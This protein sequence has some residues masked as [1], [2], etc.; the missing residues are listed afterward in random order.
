MDF[1]DL[2]LWGKVCVCWG[3][4]GG[5][6]V[7]WCCSPDGAQR[8]GQTIAST[9]RK[10]PDF[11]HCKVFDQIEASVVWLLIQFYQNLESVCCCR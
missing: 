4:G 11:Q 8:S 10:V 5:G 9:V 7:S 6:I 1:V 3:V 2:G